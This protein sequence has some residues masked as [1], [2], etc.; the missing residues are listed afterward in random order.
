MPCLRCNCIGLNL[1]GSIDSLTTDGSGLEEGVS[2][3]CFSLKSWCF[4]LCSFGV[5]DSLLFQHYEAISPKGHGF[6]V[7]VLSA[8]WNTQTIQLFIYYTDEHPHSNK[9]NTLPCPN[10]PF[11]C[12]TE[13]ST[14]WMIAR[15]EYLT[16]PSK[17]R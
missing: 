6:N 1:D 12:L 3:H 8:L 10:S 14:L 16:N 4:G 13:S 17:W 11:L 7:S 2:N 9:I 15:R 5:T